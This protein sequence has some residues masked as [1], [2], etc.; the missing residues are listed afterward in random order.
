M[1]V[2]VGEGA[3][4]EFME[5]IRPRKRQLNKNTKMVYL[6]FKREIKLCMI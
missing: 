4:R 5:R 6:C 1:R 2:V 3:G